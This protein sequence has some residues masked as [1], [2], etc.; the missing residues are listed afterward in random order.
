MD[1]VHMNGASDKGSP[2]AAV[3]TR[4]YLTS[5][6]TSLHTLFVSYEHHRNQLLPNRHLIW[7]RRPLLDKL[8]LLD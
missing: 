2:V 7:Y 4:S 5:D 1:D 6:F 3:R 8:V